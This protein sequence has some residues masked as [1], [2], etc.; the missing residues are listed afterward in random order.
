MSEPIPNAVP[1]VVDSSATNAE[2]DGESWAAESCL[3]GPIRDAADLDLEVNPLHRYRYATRRSDFTVSG[4]ILVNGM[5][6]KGMTRTGRTQRGRQVV[7]PFRLRDGRSGGV[8]ASG[9]ERN[10][11]GGCDAPDRA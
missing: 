6:Q 9:V 3:E 10:V 4:P 5:P 2:P 8:W 7:P 11:V 1:P